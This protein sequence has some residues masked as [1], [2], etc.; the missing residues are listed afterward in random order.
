MNKPI[1][2]SAFTLVELLVVIAIIGVLVGLLLPAV[3]SAREAARRMSCGNNAA[4]IALAL[5]NFEFSN[6]HLPAGV[7]HPTGPIV[8]DATGDHTSFLV[9]LLP[10]VEHRG[11]HDRYDYDAGAYAPINLEVRHSSPEVYR[12]P[13]DPMTYAMQ[14]PERA[15]AMRGIDDRPNAPS[16][17]QQIMWSME[18][19]ITNYAGCYADREVPIDTDNNGLLFLNS[20]IN[21]NDIYD[22]SSQTFVVGEM[23]AGEFSAGWV[24]GTRS[25]LRNTE[26]LPNDSMSRNWLDHDF[27]AEALPE[28]FVGGFAS[29]HPGGAN[30][31]L[32]SGAVR[33]IVQSIDQT[34]YRNL[35]NRSDGANMALTALP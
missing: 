4:Q 29:R 13:S 11:L 23:L 32:A 34:L 14:S 3:Q 1:K 30:F 28:G 12:C 6:E 35:A 16:V 15:E 25:S 7:T 21:H 31:V 5:H 33:F 19:G 27:D 2:T 22:G 9:R 24:S 10:F 8:D 18:T 20:D 17:E 26:L